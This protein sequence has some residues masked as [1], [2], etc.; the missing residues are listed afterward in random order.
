VEN[1]RDGKYKVR[2]DPRLQ[3]S[4]MTARKDSGQAGMTDKRAEMTE[5][6]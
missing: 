6:G 5:K 4:G 3:I 2:M 1:E